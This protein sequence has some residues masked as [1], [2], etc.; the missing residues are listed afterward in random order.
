M[1]N[2]LADKERLFRAIGWVVVEFQKTERVFSEVLASHLG[3]NDEQRRDIILGAF[4]FG[5]KV[6][7]YAAL[8]RVDVTNEKEAAIDIVCS[9]LRTAEEFR[10]KIVHADYYV[11]IGKKATFMRWVHKKVSVKGDK[12]LKMHR[13]IVNIRDIE[14]CA[15]IMG[16]MSLT[17]PVC[18]LLLAHGQDQSMKVG[19][20]T[21]RL[22]MS[23]T[24]RVLLRR[25]AKR[26]LG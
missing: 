23:P 24:L 4:S 5:Q 14:E 6:A 8:S 9:Y 11:V 1:D 12:G 21:K 18:L 17:A 19:A 22:K 26:H 13:Q 3:L 7:L 25:R 16:D 10:N 15:A 2:G 20:A